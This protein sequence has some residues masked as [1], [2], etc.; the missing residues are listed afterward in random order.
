MASDKGVT[1]LQE[2]IHATCH[3]HAQ[4]YELTVAEVVGVLQIE[5]MDIWNG[6]EDD[7]DE[8][9]PNHSEIPNS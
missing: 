1:R 4:E 2:A 5:Q 8:Q 6:T 7:S 9:P 3:Y